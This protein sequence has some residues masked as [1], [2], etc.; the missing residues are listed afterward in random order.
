MAR[1]LLQ[2]ESPQLRRR[3]LDV[4]FKDGR[5]Q[6]QRLENLITIARQDQHF[7]LAPTATLGLQYLFSEE[8]QYLRRQIVLALTEDDRLHTE[9]VQ[10]LWNLIKSDLRPLFLID[11]AWEALKASVSHT[12]GKEEES[13]S[14]AVAS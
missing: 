4:L 11:V 2:G 9:E 13:N 3:L 7:N 10:R 6:W 14:L 5:L 8:G 12:L 1:R